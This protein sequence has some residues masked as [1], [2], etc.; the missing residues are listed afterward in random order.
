M[1]VASLCITKEEKSNKPNFR[2]DAISYQAVASVM[3]FLEWWS[4]LVRL[5]AK[6][7]GKME[8]FIMPGGQNFCMSLENKVFQKLILALFKDLL[9]T[10]YNNSKTELMLVY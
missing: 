3:Q 8:K 5:F 4:K 2:M 1:A 7:N 10:K 6:K 9:F